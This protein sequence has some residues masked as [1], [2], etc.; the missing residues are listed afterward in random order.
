MEDIRGQARFRYGLVYATRLSPCMGAA[1][2]T[3]DKPLPLMHDLY[4][5][6]RKRKKNSAFVLGLYR[7][8]L[9]YLRD[10]DRIIHNFITLDT[11]WTEY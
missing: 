1:R 10:N 7:H 9:K 6:Q 11:P 8:C 4:R 2:T 3:A 5:G